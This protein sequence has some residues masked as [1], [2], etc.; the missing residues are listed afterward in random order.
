MVITGTNV[1]A[2]A[3]KVILMGMLELLSVAIVYI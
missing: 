1:R 3:A 2:I